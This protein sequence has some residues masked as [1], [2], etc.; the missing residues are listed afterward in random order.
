MYV[1]MHVFFK[2]NRNTSQKNGD[3]ITNHNSAATY[4]RVL[5]MVSNQSSLGIG[6]SSLDQIYKL[7][8]LHI[9]TLIDILIKINE[10][11]EN[12]GKM[13]KILQIN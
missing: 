13:V 3:V 8:K 9:Q 11:L 6:L 4:S 12:E 5:N 2:A 1:N 10:N 7:S